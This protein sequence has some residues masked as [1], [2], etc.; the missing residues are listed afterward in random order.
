MDHINH[1]VSTAGHELMHMS[2]YVS[3]RYQL[4]YSFGGNIAKA[5]A[6][7][8]AYGWE[9]S[10]GSPY[11]MEGNWGVYTSIANKFKSSLF[12]IGESKY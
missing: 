12:Q 5:F 2:D 11:K 10:M 6:E 8:R 7:S 4:W 3:G 1:L 9:I